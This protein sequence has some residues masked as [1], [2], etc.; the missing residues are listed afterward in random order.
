MRSLGFALPSRNCARAGK[1]I[2]ESRFERRSSLPASAACVVANGVRETLAALFGAPVKLRLLEPVVPDPRAWQAIARG[3]LLYRVRGSVADAV[4]VLRASD[5][6]AFASAVFGEPVVSPNRSLSPIESE[7]IERAAEAIAANLVAVCGAR[8][9]HSA[10]RV[11][12]MDGFVSFFE[13]SVEKPVETRIGVALSRDPAP[14]PRGGLEVA[15][16]AD[17]RVPVVAAIDLGDAQAAAVARLS[18]GALL[19]IRLED[20]GRCTLAA[21]GKQIGN[22]VCGVRNGRYA[23]ATKPLRGTA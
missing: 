5:A 9:G 18:V 17:V 23:I 8:E 15:H 10:E 7:V 2:R 6:I 4:I 1:R 14:E 16:L 21:A 3:A 13:M 11:A 20:L 19:P 12:A 22:G